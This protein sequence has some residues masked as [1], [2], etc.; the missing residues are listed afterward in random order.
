MSLNNDDTPEDPW[1]DNT[2]SKPAKPSG[3]KE[4]FQLHKGKSSFGKEKNTYQDR[5]SNGGNPIDDLIEK[6]QDSLKRKKFGNSGGGNKAG[7][8]FPSFSPKFGIMSFVLIGVLL[9]LSTGIYKVQDGGGEV[10]VIL[11]FGEMVRIAPVSYTHLT[12]PTNR[13]V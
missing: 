11:R 4:P 13:E 3:P 12:L 10:A 6:F 1:S 8:S 5:H 2:P 9:W 7:P